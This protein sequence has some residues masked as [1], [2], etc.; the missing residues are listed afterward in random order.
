VHAAAGGVGLAAVQIG[1]ALGARVIA[2]AGGADKLEVARAAG[3]D[4][5]VDYRAQDFVQI[6]KDATNGRGADVIYD[7]V[8]GET[9]DRSLQCI[10]WKGRLLIVG[11][12]GGEIAAIRA[13]RIM[14]KNCSVV[15]LHWPAYAS[16]ESETVTRVYRALFDLYQR[17]DIE[18]RIHAALP[19][20]ETGRALA[21]LAGRGTV[22]KVVVVP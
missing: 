15:G 8:G 2:T 5:L 21:E 22:G 11:F 3:A 1:K 14:L 17:G 4:V 16:H 13:N 18:P 9:T 6:V 20:E 12:A 19:L 10:A 7:P